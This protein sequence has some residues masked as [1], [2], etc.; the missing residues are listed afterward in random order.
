MYIEHK[1]ITSE[2]PLENGLIEVTLQDLTSGKIT[3]DKISSELIE[4]IR[5][6]EPID[7]TELK[8]KTVKAI[9]KE[10]LAVF[11]RFNPRAEDVKPI[12][13]QVGNTLSRNIE[14]ADDIKYGIPFEDRRLHIYHELL[15]E[16]ER[17][18][19]GK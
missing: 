18:P 6:E 8:E 19:S 9:E 10:L 16:A 15:T 11:L 2:I 12:L 7:A 4:C 14:H 1:L 13:Q 17:I 5:T 3:T